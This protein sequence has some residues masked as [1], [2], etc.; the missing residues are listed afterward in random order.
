MC[1][2]SSDVAFG[3]WFSWD[4]GLWVD[5][6]FRT[7]LPLCAARSRQDYFLMK[8]EKWDVVVSELLIGIDPVLSIGTCFLWAGFRRLGFI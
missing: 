1:R 4:W 5:G 6:V 3:G 2:V 7:N 8:F